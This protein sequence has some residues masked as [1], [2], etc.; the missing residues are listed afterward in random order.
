MSLDDDLLKA[1]RFGHEDIARRAL[2]D[3]A[4]PNACSS[5]KFSA[6]M[7]ATLNN[8]FTIFNLLLE[9]GAAIDAR[10]NYGQSALLWASI[11]DRPAFAHILLEKNCRLDFTDL[12]N[13]TALD[14]CQLLGH[15]PIAALIEE[16]IATNAENAVKT[17][18]AKEN[19]QIAAANLARLDRM[20]KPPRRRP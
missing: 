18:A 6:L 15:Q 12:Q 17:L 5:D 9:H 1:I 11:I 7:S 16:K 19:A 20:L 2:A 10:D 14:I 8:H 4:S 13:R 3:C